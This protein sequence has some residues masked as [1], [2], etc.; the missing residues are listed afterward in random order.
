MATKSGNYDEFYEIIPRRRESGQDEIVLVDENDEFLTRMRASTP[1]YEELLEAKNDYGD[2]P[3]DILE[4]IARQ[5]AAAYPLL[6]RYHLLHENTPT[7]A[8]AQA[9]REAEIDLVEDVFVGFDVTNLDDNSDALPEYQCPKCSHQWSGA[10]MRGTRGGEAV[11]I[12]TGRVSKRGKMGERRIGAP[13]AKREKAD[14]DG[15]ERTD[16]QD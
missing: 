13:F 5:R 15:R 11:Y 12:P 1:T 8:M 16:S 7:L 10:P 6:E 2:L 4:E 14:K 3:D 9:M